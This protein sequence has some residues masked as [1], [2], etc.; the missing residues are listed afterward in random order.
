MP[1][2]GTAGTAAGASSQ[3]GHHTL[4][5]NRS[6]ESTDVITGHWLLVPKQDKGGSRGVSPQ[7]CTQA[8]QGTYP[9]AAHPGPTS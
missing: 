8:A 7:G 5:M 3:N 9:P 6:P 1:G 4:G 2:Q